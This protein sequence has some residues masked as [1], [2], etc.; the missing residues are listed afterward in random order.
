MLKTI[1]SWQWFILLIT[2]GVLGAV[3]TAG[4]LA[5]ARQPA[6]TPV[7][8]GF[9]LAQEM[10]CFACHGP[11][12]IMGASN[13]GALWGETPPFK[14]GGAIMSFIQ[15]DED[16]KEWILY[17]TPRRL[18][19]NGAKPQAQINKVVAEKSRHD[20][21]NR[22]GV[23]G[24]I[25]MPS[26]EGLLSANE[27]EDLV[28]FIK[29]V[30]EI[31]R[32]LSAEAEKG[33]ELSERLGCLGCHGPSGRGGISNPG[34]FKGYIPPWDGDDFAELVENEDELRQWILKGKI[35]RFEANPLALY[36]THGQTIQ[37]PGFE[38]VLKQGELES[39]IAYIHW[40]RNDKEVNSKYWVEQVTP[41]IP[42]VAVRGEWLYQ[43][44]GCAAC[45]GPN[46]IGGVPNKNASGGF[47]PALD[48]IAEKMEIFEPGDVAIIITLLDRGLSLDDQSIDNPVAY[49]DG[50]LSQYE[51]IRELIL[52]G[53]IP[54]SK[55][56]L[57][58]MI[59]PAW[60]HRLYADGSPPSKADIDAIIAYLL[61]LQK[62]E[63]QDEA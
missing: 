52:K 6:S 14:A 5:H 23:G 46:G 34:S 18:W 13:Y 48:D 31:A 24:I 49:F 3:L 10:G 22:Q 57:P 50:I 38:S 11:G 44:S 17:G 15:S 62:F 33:R 12:G 58:A 63:E 45:H 32:P 26:Y 25:K 19:E 27:L 35:D 9:Y 28:A 1:Q 60:E 16:I 21:N 7:M 39:I 30:A 41:K 42:D 8:R 47:V 29:T 20:W 37:M 53:A 54:G 61:T 43:R 51:N 40:L 59:M 36:F 56:E 2:V 55:G 4:Y